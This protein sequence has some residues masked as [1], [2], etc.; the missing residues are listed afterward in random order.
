MAT[1]KK[2][3]AVEPEVEVTEP[4]LTDYEADHDADHEV[5]EVTEAPAE[6]P[7]VTEEPKEEQ[8]EEPKPEPKKEEKKADAPSEDSA[9]FAKELEGIMPTSNNLAVLNFMYKKMTG[10]KLEGYT[11]ATAQ[12]IIKDYWTMFQSGKTF[13]GVIAA[14]LFAAAEFAKQK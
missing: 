10:K 14:S 2:T 13:P 11:L 3:A 7:T 8:K 5:K 4:T 1:K 12:K 9:D 6:Q